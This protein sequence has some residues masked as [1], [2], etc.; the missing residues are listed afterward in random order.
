M[1]GDFSWVGTIHG[2]GRF[3]KQGKMFA[4]DLGLNTD[5]FGSFCVCALQIAEAFSVLHC[6]SQREQIGK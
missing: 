2:V 3:G 5:Y 4:N 6:S 1:M